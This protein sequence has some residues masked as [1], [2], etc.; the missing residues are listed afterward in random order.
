MKLAFQII[1]YILVG[2]SYD[3]IEHKVLDTDRT[4]T[5]TLIQHMH[6][7]TLVTG[8]MWL[9]HRRAVLNIRTFGQHKGRNLLGN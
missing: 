8:C 7:E 9:D 4:T 6:D 5:L 1:A 3:N 2:K